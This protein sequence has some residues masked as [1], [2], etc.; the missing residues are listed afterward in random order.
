MTNANHPVTEPE[1][2]IDT[3]GLEEPGYNEPIN[4]PDAD[5]PPLK[6]P[7]ERE[8]EDEDDDRPLEDGTE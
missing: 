7:D 8:G 3:P 6:D 1:G 5:I 2:D 4:D